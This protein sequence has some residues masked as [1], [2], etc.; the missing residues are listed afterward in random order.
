MYKLKQYTADN[1]ISIKVG[2]HSSITYFLGVQASQG[3][4]SRGFSVCFGNLP[5]A[6]VTTNLVSSHLAQKVVYFLI[7]ENGHDLISVDLV[8]MK[9]Y[10][11]HAGHPTQTWASNQLLV[12]FQHI[13]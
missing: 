1:K 3:T 9:R 10:N 7:A 5:P 6:N 12:Y 13:Q 11:I 8:A 2:G 4:V